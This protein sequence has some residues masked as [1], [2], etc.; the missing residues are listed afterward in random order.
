[1]SRRPV[2]GAR[3]ARTIRLIVAV[4]VLV[5]AAFGL[6]AAGSAANLVG[7][8]VSSWQLFPA[9]DRAI[10]E[11]VAG[12]GIGGGFACATAGLILLSS[13]LLGRWYCAALCPLGTLQELVSLLRGKRSAYRS[14]LHLLR[15]AIFAGVVA[16]AA[17]GATSIAS[18]V[19]PWSLF[20]RFV[21]YDLQ[22]LLRF[23]RSEDLPGLSWITV[24]ASGAAVLVVLVASFFRG[25]WFCGNLC[26][27]GS[28]LG[29]LNSVAP[30][31]VR[32]EQ[33]DCISCGICTSVCGASCID[34]KGKRLDSTRCVNCLD[35]LVVCPT[36]AIRYGRKAGST[37]GP[38]PPTQPTA[39][40]SHGRAQR[41]SDKAL[42][43]AQ[44][45]VAAGGGIAAI[46]SAALSKRAFAA[47]ANPSNDQRSQMPV[48]PPG[49]GSIKRFL[50]T[51]TACGLCINR[52]PSKVLQPA[53]GELGIRGLMVPRLDYSVSY[54]QYDCTLCLDVCPSGALETLSVEQ[55]HVAKI[56]DATLIRTQCIVFTNGT[57]CGACA[58]HCPTGA[59]RMVVGETGLPEP[60][61]TSAICI[62]CGACHHACP[63]SPEQAISV[64]G[65]AVQAV[66]EKPSPTLFDTAPGAGGA[67]GPG[68]APASGGSVE[69]AFPF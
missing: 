60:I 2:R 14:P 69:D 8:T 29:T 23:A 27:V 45:L 11:I 44:F 25:R 51:C 42:T 35:C 41:S 24:T 62:G 58:E 28:L 38:Q 49:A 33:D 22:S 64:S 20:S 56:G 19:D 7:R 10:G 68:G 1:M 59:V 39:R 46:S 9:A 53:L 13:A 63:V 3:T 43:R 21:T 34:G 66:A 40:D 36:G 6:L 52:C 61:F 37:E 50:R 26:P 16:L 47:G 48:V 31:R 12:F 30:L 15:A 18:W 32:L 54:C 65:L 57:K 17:I 4:I 5:A 67:S 55:K